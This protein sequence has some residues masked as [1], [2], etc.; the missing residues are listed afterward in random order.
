MAGRRR[1]RGISFITILFIVGVLAAVGLMGAQAFPSVIEYQAALKA[2]NKAQQGATVA[3]VRAIFD[4]AAD[5]DGITSIKGRDLEV[6][7]EGDA[8]VISF[9]YDKEYHMF[10]P[11]YLLLKY[12]GTSRPSR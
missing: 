9:A 6:A 4:K 7:K 8:V 5:I 10:G 1:Q 3:E 12:R 11:A 2:I